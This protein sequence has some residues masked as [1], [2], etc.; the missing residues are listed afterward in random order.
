MEAIIM[1]H[2]NLY[3]RV[4]EFMNSDSWT[5]YNVITKFP[6]EKDLLSYSEKNELPILAVQVKSGTNIAQE[7]GAEPTLVVSCLVDV[8]A[9]NQL[10]LDGVLGTLTKYLKQGRRFDVY[11]I[12]T[13]QPPGVGNYSGLTTLGDMEVG[14]MFFDK[15]DLPVYIADNRFVH[16][17]YCNFSLQLPDIN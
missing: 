3:W 8:F 15:V 9:V 17:G 16:H 11:E 10:K 13:N 5:N 7:I 4:R 14:P 1:A 6:D 2:R 12:G